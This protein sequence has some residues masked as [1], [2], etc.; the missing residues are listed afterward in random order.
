M[1]VWNQF[2]I[3]HPC[4]LLRFSWS[5]MRLQMVVIRW[6]RGIFLKYVFSAT[7]KISTIA[8]RII[9]P[10]SSHKDDIFVC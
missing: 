8:N 6:Y 2:I 3:I 9:E 10:L 1:A 5:T 4:A 7:N